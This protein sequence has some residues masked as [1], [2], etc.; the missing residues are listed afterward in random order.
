MLSVVRVR[1]GIGVVGWVEARCPS[2]NRLHP[3][4]CVVVYPVDKRCTLHLGKSSF[5]F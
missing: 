1:V 5:N 4:A 3:H 2:R